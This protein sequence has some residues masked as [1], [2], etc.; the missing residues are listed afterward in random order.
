MNHNMKRLIMPAMVLAIMLVAIIG[1]STAAITTPPYWGNQI[2]SFEYNGHDVGAYSN[3]FIGVEKFYFYP[4]HGTYGHQFQCVEYV[5][6]FYSQALGF[7]NMGD[8]NTGMNVDANKYL[9]TAPSWGL[10]PYKN[11]V[12]TT[13]PKMGDIICSNSGTSGHVAIV[14]QVI[15]TDGYPRSIRV[16]HQN[17]ANIPT[18]TSTGWTYNQ[19]ANYLELKMTKSSNGIYTV[20]NFPNGYTVAGWL[21]KP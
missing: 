20:G 21:H 5:N 13:P 1:T 14:R 3:G 2:G 16:I 18:K 4:L 11:R 10:V 9:S 8:P 7:A 12:S 17:Y 6:R 15:N 19:N